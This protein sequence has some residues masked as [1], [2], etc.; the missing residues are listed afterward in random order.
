[1]KD[2]TACLENKRDSLKACGANFPQRSLLGL[3]LQYVQ[4]QLQSS[5]FLDN[6]KGYKLIQRN[7]LMLRDADSL[8]PG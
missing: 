7:T 4:H 1:M 2:G 3:S 6:G 8:N 5:D